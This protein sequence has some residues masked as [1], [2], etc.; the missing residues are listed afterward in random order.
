MSLCALSAAPALAADG[1]GGAGLTAPAPSGNVGGAGVADPI[2]LPSQP[3][4]LG[5]RGRVRGG[6]AY[7]PMLAPLAVKRVIWAANKLRRK[8]YIYGGGHQR[9]RDRGYDCSGTVSYALHGGGLLD[10]PLDSS[11]FMKWQV[12]GRGQWITIYTNPGHAYMVVAGLRLDTS[13][14]GESGPRWRKLNRPST[15]FRARHPLGF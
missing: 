15:G 4:G 11:A 13:G 3:T 5:T 6:V 8:P 2:V 9:W 7:A 1:D 12:R 14:P 10:I